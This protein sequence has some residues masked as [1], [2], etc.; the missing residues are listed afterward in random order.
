[1]YIFFKNNLSLILRFACVL[2]N[3]LTVSILL[4]KFD[5]YEY[6]LLLTISSTLGLLLYF[7][8]GIN[9]GVR[10]LITS[11]FSKNDYRSMSKIISSTYFILILISILLLFMSFLF[12]DDGIK[13]ISF[14][15][16]DFFSIKKIGYNFYFLFFFIFFQNIS[17]FIHILLLSINKFQLSNFINLI[18]QSATFFAIFFSNNFLNFNI[19]ITSYLYIGL[20]I[21]LNISLSL[22]FFLF[23]KKMAP[24]FYY[25]DYKFIKLIFS[26][27]FPFILLQFG[28]MILLQSNT[29]LVSF[30]LG[31]KYVTEY[32]IVYKIF[33]IIFFIFN[34]YIS[35][36]WAKLA[37]SNSNQDYQN[38][39]SI[40]KKLNQN[41]IY[42]ILAT[43][44]II[45]FCNFIIKI[46]IGNSVYVSNNVI[47]SMSIYTISYLFHTTNS[48][49]L[50]GLGVI[51]KQAVFLFLTGLF[52]IPIIYL[53]SKI[54]GLSG[55]IYANSLFLIL[56]G[57][58]NKK[59][60]NNYL[61]NQN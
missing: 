11:Y 26:R 36:F 50:N 25:I 4:K 46:W 30:F 20:P 41:L 35:P 27:G 1:L 14:F 7:D 61:L 37:T 42:F 31:V 58:I 12:I 18:I 53:F 51:K 21:F 2:L 19:L 24:S 34:I 56:L 28:T 57:V 49:I 44:I 43:L 54:I 59:Q 55:V 38:I 45:P 48:Y 60:I 16:K 52:N 23:N 40:N 15:Y 32:D 33:S 17:Q 47:F 5:Q 22:I 9:H 29:I 10:N 3:T 6:G 8:F 39:I 13:I